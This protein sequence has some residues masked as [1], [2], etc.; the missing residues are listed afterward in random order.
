MIDTILDF[1]IDHA[2]VF[3]GL[4]VVTAVAAATSVIWIYGRYHERQT[5]RRRTELIS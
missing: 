4:V 1:G 3:A 5:R 2:A